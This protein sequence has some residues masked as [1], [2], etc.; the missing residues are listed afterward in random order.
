CV[1]MMMTT[2]GKEKQGVN[3]NWTQGGTFV[4]ISIDIVKIEDINNMLTIH[5]TGDGCQTRS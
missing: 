4:G 3:L 5:A 1:E 2:L